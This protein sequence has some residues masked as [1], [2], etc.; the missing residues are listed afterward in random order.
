MS[1]NIPP[2]EIQ[3]EI[4]KRIPDVKTLI[5]FRSVS[6]LWKSLI[7]SPE[8]IADYQTRH[9]NHRL[10]VRC[11]GFSRKYELIVDDDVFP[12]HKIPVTVPMFVKSLLPR[13]D[14][15]MTTS[16]GLVCCYNTHENQSDSGTKNVLL[17]NP[18]IRKSVLSLCLMFFYDFRYKT[19][20]G[21]G[22]SPHTNDPMLVKINNNNIDMSISLFMSCI[23]WHVEVFTLSTGVWRSLRTNLPRKS[24][25]LSWHHVVI[26]EFIYWIGI[27]WCDIIDKRVLSM[28]ISFD[29]RSEEFTEIFLPDYLARFYY[30]CLN[31]SK[32]RE[33]LVVLETN[34]QV[35]KL[36]HVVWIMDHGVP[37]S[38]TKLFTIKAP[39]ASIKRVF[40][41]WNSGEPIVERILMYGPINDRFVN[42]VYDPCSQR[43]YDIPIPEKGCLDSVSSYSE[44][45][46]LLDHRDNGKL[47]KHTVTDTLLT[48]GAGRQGVEI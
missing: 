45:L 10:L 3:V 46:L 47:S 4:I 31:I 7:D 26:D 27:D 18:A 12:Q 9:R 22:V 23:P 20:I 36:E 42:S 34:D 33:S 8:F 44:T 11:V 32:L 28:I 13:H 24:I 17:W 43:F 29:M 19:N 48:F 2:F 16:Q 1:D 39:D 15:S 14:I 38:F 41:F 40:G 35:E 6:K 21:F 30:D 37:N 25:D 5:Q